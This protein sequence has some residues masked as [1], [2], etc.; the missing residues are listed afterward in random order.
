MNQLEKTTNKFRK[1]IELAVDWL[2]YSKIH[3]LDFANS[4]IYGSLNDYYD[5][6]KGTC[7]HAY[8]EITAYGAELFVDLYERTNDLR[9][10][11]NANIAGNWIISMQNLRKDT[12]AVGSFSRNFSLAKEQNSSRAYS[13][14][15]GICIGALVELYRKTGDYKFFEAASKGADWLISVMQN[16]DGSFKPFYDYK[17]KSFSSLEK[18]YC[19]LPRQIKVRT[20]WWERSGAYHCKNVIGLLKLHSISNESRLEYAARKLCQWTMSQQ[21]PTGSFRVHSQSRSAFTHTHCYATE[22]LICASEYFGDKQ[23]LSAAMNAASWLVRLQKLYKRIPAWLHNGRPSF[24]NDSSSLAQAIRILGVLANLKSNKLHC[25]RTHIMAMLENL[26]K[27][28]CTRTG[29][30]D[31]LGGFYLMETGSNLLKMKLPRLYSWSTM[32]SVHALLLSSNEKTSG[33]QLW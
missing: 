7:P 33:F 22:G 23:L 20:N 29:D 4:K 25:A 18:K 17:T 5:L 3:N 28:Q 8:T 12:N 1:P 2:L 31:A 10:L 6:L 32:F 30:P 14:D 16:P 26:L 27:M 19:F 13:F 24:D 21:D 11:E 9:Y 15:A